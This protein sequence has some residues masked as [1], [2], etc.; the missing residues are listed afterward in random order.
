MVTHLGGSIM[1]W[2]HFSSAGTGNLVKVDVKTPLSSTYPGPG[3]GGSRLSR[4]TQTSLSPDTSSSSSTGSPRRSQASRERHSPSSVSWAVPWASSRWDVP[5]TPP[6][7]GVQE[8][9]S[10]DA[11][12][13]STGSSHC[14]GAEALLRAPPGRAPHPIYK[15]ELGHP[16]EE[17]HFSRLYLGSR[18]FCHDPKFMVRV[19]T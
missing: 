1:L 19:G 11:R 18:S 4:D 9:S 6:E 16:T 12:A 15:G 13:T 10:I 8:T 5:G 7:E 2:E 17:A 14:G 3:H